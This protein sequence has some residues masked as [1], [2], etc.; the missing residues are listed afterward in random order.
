MGRSNFVITT[1]YINNI[2]EFIYYILHSL[3][4]LG[5]LEENMYNI[6]YLKTHSKLLIYQLLLVC[7]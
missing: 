3:I 5:S 6:K 7:H 2:K 1:H 4:T